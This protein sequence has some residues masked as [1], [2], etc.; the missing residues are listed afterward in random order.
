[1]IRVWDVNSGTKHFE[2]STAQEDHFITDMSLDTSGRRLLTSGRDGLVK[3][4]IGRYVHVHVY[5]LC[6]RFLLLQLP[7]HVCPFECTLKPAT[8]LNSIP[9]SL[10]PIS[11]RKLLL[12]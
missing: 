8:C 1:M 9:Q 5:G 6:G 12:V 7:S 4:G 11:S 10:L 2:F 3:V